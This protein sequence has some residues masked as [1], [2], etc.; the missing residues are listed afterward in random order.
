MNELSQ[1]DV[2]ILAGGKGTRLSPVIAG[3]PKVLAE[4]NGRP[5]LEHL[6]DLLMRS[7]FRRVILCTGHESDEVA[8][9]I[10]TWFGELCIGYSVESS[11]LGT[12]GAVRNALGLIRSDC[13]FV[14]NGDS[15]HDVD[16]ASLLHF[17]QTREADAT[18]TLLQVDNCSRFGS[19]EINHDQEIVAFA[20]KK[21][22][23]G[24][25]L[26]NA[27]IYVLN[28]NIIAEIPPGED[29]SIELD[30]FPQWIGR[31]FF[32]FRST[33]AFIDIGTP[34]SYAAAGRFFKQVDTD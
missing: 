1:V 12:G 11:P 23:A 18:I 17:H 3:K 21:K 29:I 33:G 28:D 14:L 19:V 10:G 22:Q 9:A 13:V 5:Y 8:K 25:G 16:F 34:E 7:G 32:G 6:L 24:P 4:I 20:E 30:V 26:I 15:F 2:L 27:G 31:R